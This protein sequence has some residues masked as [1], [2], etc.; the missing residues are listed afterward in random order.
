MVLGIL[1]LDDYKLKRLKLILKAIKD[2]CFE[3]I[4]KPKGKL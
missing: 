2:G 4:G 3:N 1:L